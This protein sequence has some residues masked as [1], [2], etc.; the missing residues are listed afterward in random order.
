MVFIGSKYPAKIV[1]NEIHN[2]IAAIRLSKQSAKAHQKSTFNN[3]ALKAFQALFEELSYI[4]ELND[5]DALTY[6]QPFLK[7]I[8]SEETHGALTEAALNAVSKFVTFGLI[9]PTND[10]SSESMNSLSWAVINCRF[11]ASKVQPWTN[12][13]VLLKIMHT[14]V[15]CI[16]SEPGDYL[17]DDCVWHMVKKCYQ[18][19]RQPGASQLLR[20]S[21]E[22][23]LVQLIHAI[24]G[25]QKT[26]SQKVMQSGS[27]TQKVLKPY[28]FKAMYKVLKFVAYLM[29]YGYGTGNTAD[30]GKR[31][32]T[33][34]IHRRSPSPRRQGSPARGDS[35]DDSLG[36]LD[37]RMEDSH[38]IR[39]AIRSLGMQLLNIALETGGE[40]VA[41]S[42]EL[43]ELIQDE[44]C[45]YLLRNSR[46]ESLQMLS[47]VLRC[48][49]NLF[50]HFK[51]H[52]KVQLEVFFM[53]IHLK[54]GGNKIQNPL[55]YYQSELAME[56]L[57]EF[58]REPELMHEL[59][60]NYDCDVR[61]TNLFETLVKFLLRH[62]VPEEEDEQPT[63][64]NRLA[65]NGLTSILHAISLRCDIKTRH[66]IQHHRGDP[67]SEE[68]LKQK[69]ELKKRVLLAA[70]LFNSD[71]S[72][73]T[74]QLQNLGMLPTPF[75]AES[76]AKFLKNTTGLDLRLVG[77]YLGKRK[78]FNGEV[79]GEFVKL[80]DFTNMSL[81]E[82]L[83]MFLSTF[84]LPGE[85][86]LIERLVES[87]ATSYYCAQIAAPDAEA[88]PD[89]SKIARIVPREKAL[90]DND[91][92]EEERTTRICNS[93]TIFILS[94][95]IIMLNTDLH[96]PNVKAPMTV[97]EF[98]RN[99][100]GIDNGQDVVAYYL[101]DIYEA[102]RDDEIRLHGETAEKDDSEITDAWEGVLM[103]SDALDEFAISV[104]ELLSH[105]PPGTVEREMFN[106]I[107]EASPITVFA[108]CLELHDGQGES[109]AI[110]EDV[111]KGIFDM[112]K[113][114][115]YFGHV[116]SINALARVSAQYFCYIAPDQS[117][118]PKPQILSIC[119]NTR[120]QLAVEQICKIVQTFP[121]Q[122]GD[123]W[124]DIINAL[125][126]AW[127]LGLLN[128]ETV[129][130][131]DF[132]TSDGKPLPKYCNISPSFVLEPLGSN[133]EVQSRTSNKVAEEGFFSTLTKWFD[134]EVE[135]NKPLLTKEFDAGGEAGKEILPPARLP[136]THSNRNVVHLVLRQ[137]M[138]ETGK[139]H[140]LFHCTTIIHKLPDEALVELSKT[141]VA[142]SI[143]WD[144]DVI[145]HTKDP[146]AGRI[147]ALE[148]LTNVMCYIPMVSSLN[149]EEKVSVIWPFVSTH[150]ERLLQT[151]DGDLV[152]QE[153]VIVNA[154][155]LCNSL[156]HRAPYIPALVS[157]LK[158]IC[159][160]DDT[161][162][163]VHAERVACGLSILMRNSDSL[164]KSGQGVV[165]Q[166]LKR[167]AET[168]NESAQRAGLEVLSHWMDVNGT[169]KV[170]VEKGFVNV[171][172]CYA[173]LYTDALQFL[174]KICNF[175]IG[176]QKCLSSPESDADPVIYPIN[177][178]AV[179]AAF[180]PE[181]GNKGLF[182]LQNVLLSPDMVAL[183]FGVWVR[184][185]DEVFFPLLQGTLMNVA[186]KIG[187]LSNIRTVRGPA[188]QVFCR[189]ML[190]H[191]QVFMT[192]RNFPAVF[193]RLIH[194]LVAHPDQ[195]QHEQIVESL[196]N[197]LL[198]ISSDA[199]FRRIYFQDKPLLGSLWSIVEP[200]LPGFHENIMTMFPTSPETLPLHDPS[201]PPVDDHDLVYVEGSCPQLEKRREFDARVAAYESPPMPLSPRVEDI[202][203]FA[204][205]PSVVS[206]VVERQEKTPVSLRSSLTSQMMIGRVDPGQDV[207]QRQSVPSD[208]AAP[209]TPLSSGRGR[210][211]EERPLQ[212]HGS[213]ASEKERGYTPDYGEA[214]TGRENAAPGQSSPRLIIPSQVRLSQ[215]NVSTTNESTS[216]Q[217]Q[218]QFS[219][220]AMGRDSRCEVSRQGE[221]DRFSYT[222]IASPNDEEP[223]LQGVSSP[224]SPQHYAPLEQQQ[225]SEY[226]TGDME[227]TRS[228]S[229][230]SPRSQRSGNEERWAGNQERRPS[231]QGKV[232]E[233]NPAASGY[234]DW[235]LVSKSGSPSDPL[236]QRYSVQPYPGSPDDHIQQG[237]TASSGIHPGAPGNQ[238]QQG[239]NAPVM[240]PG[241]PEHQNLQDFSA[242]LYPGSPVDPIQQGYAPPMPPGSPVDPIQQGYAPPTHP[243]SPVDSSIQQRYSTA[244]GMPPGAPP[245]DNMQQGYSAPP[246]MHPGYMPPV[247]P[248]SPHSPG[249]SAP[250]TSYASTSSPS[251]QGPTP[252]MAA[253]SSYAPPPPP[254]PLL[255][256]H[257]SSADYVTNPYVSQS[258]H[259]SQQFTPTHAQMLYRSATQQI[260]GAQRSIAER[261]ANLPTPPP[262]GGGPSAL[263]AANRHTYASAGRSPSTPSLARPYSPPGGSTGTSPRTP[264]LASP[265]QTGTGIRKPNP[266]LPP[267]IFHSY[268]SDF[269]ANP[270]R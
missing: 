177:A 151:K 115:S 96:N 79:R 63:S 148:I 265:T 239:Y 67:G 109:N 256:P 19:S 260:P 270:K 70:K 103:K 210:E 160:L 33:R 217:S 12:E 266:V 166:L 269:S 101:S 204:R 264:P 253:Y 91:I 42:T 47:I 34:V 254:P 16:R 215:K 182:E 231:I 53:S 229:S 200:I 21:G 94:Y 185:F 30:D 211:R 236:Q 107:W 77:E 59:Y 131:D 145:P 120:S 172:S 35:A 130:F 83:R 13:V 106:L 228:R 87:F 46:S 5:L 219:P 170:E 167:I 2:I 104:G 56:S 66:S 262:N 226:P 181:L 49:F 82:G 147:V 132:S 161:A 98:L 252:S 203:H 51:K 11:A 97:E 142:L 134:D 263:Q 93:D 37:S 39:E 158:G 259:Q 44:I 187:S 153:R 244:G 27:T 237:Y 261:M 75:S 36:L 223:I 60:E 196:K 26:R 163:S 195:D 234:E 221:P 8:E 24:F 117:N 258:P 126:K 192:H 85:A 193:L 57:L 248:S 209:G 18:I 127:T 38:E 69:K 137:W 25:G 156:G 255:S 214:V 113:I 41:K 141:L 267:P 225:Q 235:T 189:L 184:L 149:D 123:A 129:G 68:S 136:I 157:L 114:G 186:D 55:N 81:V 112:A 71:P 178:I 144:M 45:K 171:L 152:I 174:V 140:D 111:A 108:S 43:I 180:S 154:M 162:F 202:H 268:A 95:S 143:Q 201:S 65:L 240:P 61:C 52:L 212:Q 164:D 88:N 105:T 54:I 23:C 155:R 84:R 102:I 62:V 199:K 72:K 191:M 224:A 92:P 220:L 194:I 176:K 121:H 208:Y 230:T 10:F 14:C 146:Q 125:Y 222:V 64:L 238:I 233:M 32:K 99:N 133:A 169:D 175:A 242:P 150:F 9:H 197:L 89:P 76:M 50:N 213:T 216:M 48:V 40:E 246:G 241:S 78:E 188:A 128:E 74:N 257:G 15:D 159:S 139:L 86:Q 116:E 3:Q 4:N 190:T 124:R 138:E 90:F 227:A 251:L 173:L 205:K 135:T 165:F 168:Q 100:R 118:L 232:I 250:S 245:G 249:Y 110:A 1:K 17:S 119:L 28:G 198:V 179:V 22:S 58:C 243:G 183:D 122:L 247:A 7:M 31:T 20:A 29:A 80:F 206:A 73:C 218:Q 207:L 6:L